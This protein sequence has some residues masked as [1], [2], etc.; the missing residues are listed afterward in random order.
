MFIDYIFR[1]VSVV[2]QNVL[3]TYTLVDRCVGRAGSLEDIPT[4]WSLDVL[5]VVLGAGETR[6]DPVS[7]KSTIFYSSCSFY[8]CVSAVSI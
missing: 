7:S 8:I 4:I 3:K 6:Q 1:F 2:G 5:I